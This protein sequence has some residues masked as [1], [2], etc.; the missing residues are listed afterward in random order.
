M[1][2]T[3]DYAGTAAGVLL[4]FMFYAAYIPTDFVN[5]VHMFLIIIKF[6]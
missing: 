5:C 4:L 2:D 1:L 3:T 6:L